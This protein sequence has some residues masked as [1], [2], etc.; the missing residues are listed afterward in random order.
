MITVLTLDKDIERSM[1]DALNDIG[2]D[3]CL[4]DIHYRSR[5]IDNPRDF[6]SLDIALAELGLGKQVI[7]FGIE[8][9]KIL[10]QDKR[11]HA[12]M[13]NPNFAYLKLPI[14]ASRIVEVYKTLGQGLVD[15]LALELLSTTSEEPFKDRCLKGVFCDIEN[16]LLRNG[17]INKKILD[18]LK[19]A[20]QNMLPITIWTGGN[21]EKYNRTLRK[22]GIFWKIAPKQLFR[23]STVEYAIDDETEQ[24]LIERYNIRCL[25][26]EK[27]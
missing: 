4:I 8:D 2:M 19:A 11:Y 23:G 13:G 9:L 24:I 6:Q 10:T 16:T 15:E 14:A 5:L 20:E 26:L 18:K 1:Q 25:C 27:A 22:L 21:S 3:A 17:K 12:C 7:M